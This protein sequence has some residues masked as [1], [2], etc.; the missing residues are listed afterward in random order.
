MGSIP[1]EQAMLAIQQA[2]LAMQQGLIRIDHEQFTRV[3]QQLQ[4]AQEVIIEAKQKASAN[5]E[6]LLEQ[7]SVSLFDVM[8]QLHER[9]Q[10]SNLQNG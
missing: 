4:L 9:K 3:E 5:E 2:R 6:Q 1:I 10:P 8:E 7:A